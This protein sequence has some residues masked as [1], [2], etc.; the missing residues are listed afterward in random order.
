MTFNG[1]P[2]PTKKWLAGLLVIF[3]KE[4]RE[5]GGREGAKERELE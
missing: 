4:A 3:F 5:I 2:R 1:R